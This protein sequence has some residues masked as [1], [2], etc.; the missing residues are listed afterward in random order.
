M[1]NGQETDIDMMAAVTGEDYFNLKM[2]V[3][4]L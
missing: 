3:Y 1:E 4:C 2:K